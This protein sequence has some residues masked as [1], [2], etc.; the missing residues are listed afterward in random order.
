MK[1]IYLAALAI[2]L[3][4]CSYN[5]I[6]IEGI[7]SGIKEA[8]VEIGNHEN[9][10]S[11]NIISNKF[12]I[13]AKIS[14]PDFYQFKLLFHG[15][16]SKSVEHTIYLEKGL[17]KITLDSL[18]K[19][20]PEIISSSETQDDL[21][22][23]FKQ[24]L[25]SKQSLEKFIVAHPASL[26]SA[27]LLSK[28]ENAIRNEPKRYHNLYKRL[29]PEIQKSA[30]GIIAERLIT[31]HV[32]TMPGAILPHLNGIMP[33]GRP[34][35]IDSLK[36]KLTAIAIWGDRSQ[37]SLDDLPQ[38][39]QY[40]DDYHEKGFEIL[41]ISI[42]KS[43]ERWKKSIESNQLKWLHVSDFKAVDSENFV[44]LNVK[45]FPCY[46]IVG[47]DLKIIDHTVPLESIPIYIND[48]LRE[49]STK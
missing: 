16:N 18:N 6:R 49:K 22:E 24:K 48:F 21:N 25:G 44:Q 31:G 14:E 36:G 43:K 1:I 45:M 42:S 47:P 5:D 7:A 27:Y 40:Y 20:Y 26:A 35:D 38:L 33:N 17:F 28:S 46:I 4:G 32:R 29:H 3:Y 8:V 10:W 39:K 30:Y 19:S 9:R 15:V 34:L 23:Y 37:S 13:S 2:L 12:S 41:S 11:E